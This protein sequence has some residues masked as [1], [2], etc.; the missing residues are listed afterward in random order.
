MAAPAALLAGAAYIN[1]RA[2]IN[3][4]YTLITGLLRSSLQIALKSRRDKLNLF[5]VLEQKALAKCTANDVSLMYE[6]T[7]WTFRELYDIVLAHG[8][9]LKV[10]YA[11]EP[12]E[13]VAMDFMNSPTFIFLWFGLWSIGAKPAFIN[14][15]LTGKPLVHC[16]RTSTARIVFV[17]EQVRRNFT[18]DV[19]TTLATPPAQDGTAPVQTVFFNPEV[20]SQ[21][22]VTKGIREPDSSR[23]GDVP[24]DMALLIFTSGEYILKS[25]CTHLC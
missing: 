19:M 25:G 9:W 1:A 6:G 11:I 15:N 12:K 5:Y 4:D 22:L 8:T 23:C 24:P 2:Q 21:I 14:Y 13:V 18:Q 20:Q 17:D 7:S 16:V 3:N 10:T